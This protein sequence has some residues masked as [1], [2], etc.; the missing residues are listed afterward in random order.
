M[1]FKIRQSNISIFIPLT[2]ILTLTVIFTIAYLFH[3]QFDR[4][5]IFFIILPFISITFIISAILTSRLKYIEIK[6]NILIID[7]INNIKI[8]DIDYYTEN[9]TLLFEGLKIKKKDGDVLQLSNLV[10]FKKRSELK[11][12]KDELLKLYSDLTGRQLIEHDEVIYDKNLNLLTWTKLFL[13]ILANTFWIIISDNLL[14]K[15]VLI[16]ISLIIIGL[17]L[18]KKN[19]ASY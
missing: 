12:L 18:F 11:L 5:I 10:V 16:F 14:N 1:N 2:V 13:I 9:S 4:I 6:N 8:E 17:I 3:D 7:N 19:K 15:I